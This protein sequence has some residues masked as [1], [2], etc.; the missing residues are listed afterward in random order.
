MN[1][2][3]INGETEWN[4]SQYEY[5]RSPHRSAAHG[6]AS[7]QTVTPSR[8]EEPLAL[9]CLQQ[10]QLLEHSSPTAEAV[11]SIP[12]SPC[13]DTGTGSAALASLCE[14]SQAHSS[15]CSTPGLRPSPAPLPST[16]PGQ[17]VCTLGLTAPRSVSSREEK[18]SDSSPQSGD[19][20]WQSL[21]STVTQSIVLSMPAILGHCRAR[22]GDT[23]REQE[24]GLLL[25]VVQLLSP[26]T[27][28]EQVRK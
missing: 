3:K 23:W 1:L 17:R 25:M 24:Q 19:L 28:H 5:S 27:D 11:P 18:L 26:T 15:S 8:L 13:L 14:L 4:K 12:H 7:T 20:V 21:F 9:C 22:A 10:H 16:A 2:I 6:S